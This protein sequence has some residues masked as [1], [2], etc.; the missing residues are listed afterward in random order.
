[1]APFYTAPRARLVEGSAVSHEEL[2]PRTA[3]VLHTREALYLWVGA[4]AH[5]D[6]EVQFCAHTH[7]TLT[8]ARTRA[9]EPAWP[10]L[11]RPVARGRD[12]LTP[13]R[14]AQAA[15]REWTRLL[16]RFEHAS[17]EVDRQR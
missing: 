1:M 8:H 15:A 16:Q 10:R 12:A 6:Y 2:D 3:F 5:P 9:P 7:R 4:H 13:L 11:Q 17:A 14:A